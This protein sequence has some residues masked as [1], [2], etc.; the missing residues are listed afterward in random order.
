MDLYA[1]NTGN[2]QRGVIAMEEFGLP[3][4][5][6]RVDL[7]KGESRT[8]QFL[9]R[10]PMG[11]IP[12]LMDPDGPSGKPVTLSQS[13]AILMYM[14]D[15]TGGKLMPKDPNQRV[16]TME[17]MMN[18]C[19]DIAVTSGAIAQMSI[20]AKEKV[21][22]SIEHFEQRLVKY[23]RVCDAQ[24]QGRDYLTGNELTIADLALFPVVHGRKALADKAGDLPNLMRW[25]ATMAARPTIQRALKALA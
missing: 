1:A 22:S 3:Y 10:N 8:P 16:K 4:R 6:T 11:Q 23:F 5:L 13:G 17:W 12:V 18:G 25:Y 21:P 9:E 7:Q 15:K 20:F 24:L 2:G 19:T 14:V